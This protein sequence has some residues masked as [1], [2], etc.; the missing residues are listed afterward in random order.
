MKSPG[1]TIQSGKSAQPKITS[2]QV[3]SDRS[4]STSPDTKKRS[5]Q[6]TCRETI[7]PSQG[8]NARRSNQV[9]YQGDASPEKSVE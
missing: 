9:H 6:R 2:Q 5:G 1:E 7:C 3:R 8:Y 4:F